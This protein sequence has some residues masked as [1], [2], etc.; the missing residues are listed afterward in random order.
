MLA[1]RVLKF[2]ED[3]EK[4][5]HSDITSTKEISLMNLRNEGSHVIEN[6]NAYEIEV[7]LTYYFLIQ[8]FFIL[9]YEAISLKLY[10]RLSRC[11]HDIHSDIL[12]KRWIK[13]CL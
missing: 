10:V 12:G 3:I 9:M 11:V 7:L 1:M 8:V 6:F 5:L 4:W 13:K 2:P